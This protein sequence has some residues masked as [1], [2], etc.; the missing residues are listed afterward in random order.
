MKDF[1]EQNFYELL[2][3]KPHSS[4]Q[5]VEHSYLL[6]RRF[7]SPDSVATYALFQPEELVLLRR[8]IEE[9]FRV[10]SDPERRRRYDQ[11]MASLEGGGWP[12]PLPEAPVSPTSET[13]TAPV[14]AATREEAALP[15]GAPA[16]PPVAA[17]ASSAP[18]VGDAVPKPS[19]NPPPLTTVPE[20]LVEPTVAPKPPEP[21]SSPPPTEPWPMPLIDAHTC[22]TGDL[23][24]QI[25][26]AKGLTLERVAEITKINIFYLRTLE[27]EDQRNFPAEV[28]V[29]GYLRMLAGVYGQDP[30]R[31]IDDYLS[32]M[33]Q[34]K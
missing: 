8:R 3:V 21:P 23:L 20:R 1:R 11:E 29:K 2:D 4:G 9:A 27:E 17:P 12:E 5:E 25:R 19:S 6:A 18:G 22:Y 16:A 28:Y 32:R 34:K 14:Q 15:V 30:R 33:N 7:L 10:L 24:K 31:C 13:A 26:R